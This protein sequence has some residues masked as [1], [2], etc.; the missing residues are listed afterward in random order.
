MAIWQYTLL[1]IPKAH[2]EDA[3]PSF[4]NQP[5]TKYRKETS[6]FWDQAIIDFKKIEAEINKLIPKADFCFSE[7]LYF[8]SPRNIG[9]NDCSI[10][11]KGDKI[12]S[13]DLRVDL[14]SDDLKRILIGLI[15]LC[16]ESQF[17]LM[18]LR[19]EIIE[20]EIDKILADIKKSN[21][22]KF[23]TNPINFLESLK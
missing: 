6:F 10:Y 9:D 17:L 12:I 3:Y 5:V 2:F 23:L 8:K 1:I 7:T 18:N 15:N 16:N 14:R 4:M 21:T 19:Y 13:F 22:L 20:T 11:F